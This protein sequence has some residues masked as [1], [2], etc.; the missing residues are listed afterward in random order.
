MV[1][2][3]FFGS[4][5]APSCNVYLMQ[6]RGTETPIAFNFFVT[7]LC[8]VLIFVTYLFIFN[9]LKYSFCSGVIL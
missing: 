8:F 7:F 2:I 5:I 9:V 3:S 4:E 6:S 1:R